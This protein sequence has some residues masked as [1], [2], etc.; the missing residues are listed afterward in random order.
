MPGRANLEVGYTPHN[1]YLRSK[2]RSGTA[3]GP[4][5]LVLVVLGILV[6]GTHAQVT[7][8]RR[9]CPD[10]ELLRKST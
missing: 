8:P 2:L 4:T 9:L 10:L 1:G 3:A 7:R 5:C 6:P